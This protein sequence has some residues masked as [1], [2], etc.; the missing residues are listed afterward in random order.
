[1]RSRAHALTCA[2]ALPLPGNSRALPSNDRPLPGKGRQAPAVILAAMRRLRL[3]AR[4]CR[5]CPL[6]R[7]LKLMDEDELDR[8]RLLAALPEDIPV[9]RP[10][11]SGVHP[12]ECPSHFA[13]MFRRRAPVGQVAASCMRLPVRASSGVRR[14]CLISRYQTRRSRSGTYCGLSPTD[15]PKVTQSDALTPCVRRAGNVLLLRQRQVRHD[16]DALSPGMTH[17]LTRG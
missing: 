11:G 1:M 5:D 12:A 10:C 14:A 16:D 8:P 7:P 2:V 13:M 3:G 17:R 6:P 15:T 4:S 9:A